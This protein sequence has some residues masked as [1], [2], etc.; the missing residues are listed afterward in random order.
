MRPLLLL[1]ALLL[2]A[3][4]SA[5]AEGPVTEHLPR[6]FTAD[7]IRDQFVVGLHL[8]W[9]LL[10][11]GVTTVSDWNVIK[12]DRD[13]VTIRYETAGEEP[14]EATHGWVE[15]RDHATFARSTTTVE[16]AAVEALGASRAGRR[17][18]RVTTDPAGRT[19]RETF[20]F[21]LDLPGPPTLMTK[22]VAG[23]EVF[24]MTQ[25]VREP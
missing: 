15:L 4:P 20:D 18:T 10:A 17:F 13:G 12:A 9:E 16:D 6:P 5:A 3:V 14:E 2:V 8:R 7:Q 25:V 23:E 24:R 21:A 11:G 1:A 22:T 19:V